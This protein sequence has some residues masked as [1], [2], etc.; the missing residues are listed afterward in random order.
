[1]FTNEYNKFKNR[2]IKKKDKI[3]Y[4]NSRILP[5]RTLE[6]LMISFLKMLISITLII[7]LTLEQ[8]FIFFM[9]QFCDIEKNLGE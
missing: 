8:N 6:K 2:K 4:K 7:Q 1:M 3:K 5:F 9:L